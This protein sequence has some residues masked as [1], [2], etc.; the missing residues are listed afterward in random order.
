MSSKTKSQYICQNCGYIS[1]R[2]IGK[3][4]ECENWNT[5]IEEII[6]TDEKKKDKRIDLK[7]SSTEIHTIRSIESKRELRIETKL[8]EFDRVLGGGLVSGSVVLIGGDPGIGK[9]TLMLQIAENLS[10]KKFL[11]VTGEES[12][13][14]IKMRADRLNFNRDNFFILP[15]T[16]L[17]IVQAIIY[18]NNPDIVV[19][20]SIQTTY[21]S[22]LESTPGTISQLRES[23]A[24]L[25]NIAKS[26]GT[27]ILIVGHITK[28]GTIAG[29]KVLE[30]MVDVVLHFEGERTHNYRI[31]RSIKN[32]FGSTN[33]IGIFEM[34]ENGLREVKNPSEVFLSQRNYGASGCV[35]SSAIEGTRPILIEVQALVTET[36]Y[37]F[38]QRTTMGIDAKKLNIIIAVLEKKLGLYLN[39][40]D[41]FLNIA[42]GVKIS[43]PSIDLAIAVS[44]F[45]SFRDIPI[46]SETV[47]LGELGLAGEVRTISNIERRINEAEK[48]GFKRIIIPRNNLKNLQS[49]KRK[50]EII[51]VEKL[52]ETVSLLI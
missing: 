52:K 36:S 14:Q 19:I 40:H 3:C 8:E 30:H 32:R 49:K 38:P 45:S 39:K 10:D 16:D 33:E 51:G 35:I 13:V 24:L 15:E 27:P 17:D 44:I 37:G 5:F 1:P 12:P 18:K 28:D 9:S 46:D 43:E 26:T 29:P 23:T 21:I 41:I 50:I 25:I 4:P 47:I 34:T 22:Q 11:Y 48:L 7:A 42:G 2:W 20:D 6:H 31:L